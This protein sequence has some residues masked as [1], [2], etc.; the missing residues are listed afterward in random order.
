M[1]AYASLGGQDA[2][3]K[4]LGKQAFPFK[5]C[6]FTPEMQWQSRG[7]TGKRLR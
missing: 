2:G 5:N 1:Q 4:K 3:K 7:L 6:Q